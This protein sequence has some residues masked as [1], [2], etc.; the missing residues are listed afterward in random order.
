MH[1]EVIERK[2]EVQQSILANATTGQLPEW[3]DWTVQTQ[4]YK[5]IAH[6]HTQIALTRTW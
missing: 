3:L 1:V 6:T 2:G 5:S 4:V